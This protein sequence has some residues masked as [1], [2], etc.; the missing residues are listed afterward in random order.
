M[1]REMSE[2]QEVRVLHVDGAEVTVRVEE[3]HPDMPMLVNFAQEEPPFG[4]QAAREFILNCVT[5]ELAD[6][7]NSFTAALPHEVLDREYPEGPRVEDILTDMA[8][9]EVEENDDQYAE[10]PLYA[11]TYKLTWRYPQHAAYFQPGRAYISYTHEMHG[12]VLH[13]GRH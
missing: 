3:T 2:Y 10:S 8:L 4:S 11:L 13:G 7:G 12:L 6:D 1:E 5:E 9:L